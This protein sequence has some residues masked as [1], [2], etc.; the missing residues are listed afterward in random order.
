[1]RC[2]WCGPGRRWLGQR[3]AVDRRI[4][5]CLGRPLFDLPVKRGQKRGAVGHAN[6]PCTPF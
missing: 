2:G 3:I 1:V 4:A 6:P 5:D